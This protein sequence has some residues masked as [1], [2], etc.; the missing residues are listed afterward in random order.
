[1]LE[2][3]APVLLILAAESVI[4]Y[5]VLGSTDRL[6]RAM[7]GG[8]WDDDFV[9]LGERLLERSIGRAVLRALG[10]KEDP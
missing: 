6:R 3:W 4:L 1:M 7:R 10:P 9:V 2:T 5:H 8:A